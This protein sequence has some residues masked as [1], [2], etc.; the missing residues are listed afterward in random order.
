MPG[1][2]TCSVRVGARKPWKDSRAITPGAGCNRATAGRPAAARA[3]RALKVAA[4]H[5]I[6]V[7][8]PS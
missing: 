8:Q 4:P 5:A 7:A 3:S 6:R 2:R 1:R